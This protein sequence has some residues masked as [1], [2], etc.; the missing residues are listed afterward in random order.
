MPPTSNDD[1]SKKITDFEKILK[2]M[3]SQT[4]LPI[5]YDDLGRFTRIYN[6]MQ[7]IINLNRIIPKN[8]SQCTM[9]VSKQIFSSRTSMVKLTELDEPLSPPITSG[10]TLTTDNLYNLKDNGP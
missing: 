1:I 8:K 5:N 7:G 10:F 9:R 4:E 6:K 3:K 2:E